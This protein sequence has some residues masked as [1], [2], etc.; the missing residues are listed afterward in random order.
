MPSREQK[1]LD[2]QEALHAAREAKFRAQRESEREAREKAR[3]AA[4]NAGRRAAEEA[5][6]DTLARCRHRGNDRWLDE[7]DGITVDSGSPRLLQHSARSASPRSARGQSSPSPSP[8][9]LSAQRMKRLPHETV[10]HA[11]K[12]VVVG[13]GVHTAIT[14]TTAHF[15]IEARD[16]SGERRQAGG[17]PFL[18]SIRGTSLVS[19]TVTDCEDGSYAVEFRTPV[20]GKYSISITLCGVHVAGERAPRECEIILDAFAADSA[21]WLSHL[22]TSSSP[23]CS[24]PLCPYSA[25]CA[26]RRGAM[27]PQRPRAA[28]GDF[29]RAC[30]IHR[31]IFGRRRADN[32]R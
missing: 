29:P 13:E 18:V 8:R 22:A 11:A 31:R 21:L 30:E 14:R 9:R 4:Q 25:R 1:A 10:A 27:H 19:S 24:L 23:A 12:S 3:R 2:E 20:S 28:L 15:T 6:I 17:D 16:A 32:A 26:A 5:K 7:E